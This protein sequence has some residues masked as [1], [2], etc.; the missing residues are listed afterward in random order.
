LFD[1]ACDS[2]ADGTAIDYC[3]ETKVWTRYFNAATAVRGE[4][5]CATDNP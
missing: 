2:V 1:D 3:S 5:E 4:V